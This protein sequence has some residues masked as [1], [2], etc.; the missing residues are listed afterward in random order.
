M[1]RETGPQTTIGNMANFSVEEEREKKDVVSSMGKKAFDAK[2]KK[3]GDKVKK[4]KEQLATK[5]K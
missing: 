3:W 2:Q 4:R 5:I 1:L